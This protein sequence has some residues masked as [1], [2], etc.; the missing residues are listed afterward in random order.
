MATTKASIRKA[1]AAQEDLKRRDE[2]C[3][4]DPLTLAAIDCSIR[5]QVR[6]TRTSDEYGLYTISEVRQESAQGI[7]RMGLAGRRRLETDEAFA[8]V[9][10]P[11]VVHPTLS[12]DEAEALGEFVERLDDDGHN[13]ALIVIAPHGG[14]IEPHT[15]EQA[16]R[17][18]SRLAGHGASCWRCKGFKNGGGASERWHIT[19]ADI[20]EA[21]FPRLNEV[22]G[23][24]FAHAF[25][26]HGFVEPE[27]LVGGLAD[28][29]LK[30]EI[31]AAIDG[32]MAGTG[33]DVRIAEPCD[34]DNGDDERNIV[35]R[36][37][38][39]GANGVQIEQP[40]KARR[41]YGLAIADAVAD[42]YRSKL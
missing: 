36:L 42:V 20:S 21:S 8:A 13:R 41:N 6:V 12:G 38:A 15:A 40:L 25:A 3:S 14:H 4:M 23:R 17:V 26:F 1:L 5:Q 30:Q 34:P 16:E 29:A 22:V 31:K 18:A 10:D 7:V 11:Q 2:H 9:L 32:A 28:M 37:T 35:N 19:S 33:F 24:G 27:I 39:G